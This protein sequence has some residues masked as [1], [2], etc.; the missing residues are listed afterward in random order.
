MDRMRQEARLRS[1]ILNTMRE[2]NRPIHATEL[3]SLLRIRSVK[4]VIAALHQL[5][6][7]E[8]VRTVLNAKGHPGYWALV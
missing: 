7:V 3:K 4:P 1:S 5:L 6:E 8:E 2:E